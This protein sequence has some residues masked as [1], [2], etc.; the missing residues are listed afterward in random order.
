VT[1]GRLPDRDRADVEALV[2]DH[3]LEALLASSERRAGD[4]PADAAL[5]PALR[6]AARLLQ[7][8]L[9]RVHP[10]FR[11]EERLAAQLAALAAD[12][13]AAQ[14]GRPVDDRGAVV[15]FATPGGTP[16]GR[17]RGD[18]PLD[19][20]PDPLLPAILDGTLDPADD[21]VLEADPRPAGA[22]RPLLLGGAITSAAIS[23]V[24]VAWVAWRAA[25]PIDRSLRA[26]AMTRT[27]QVAHGRRLADAPMTGGG[28]GGTA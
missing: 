24:G 7:R 4:V 13:R 6:D 20:G 2:A 18:A 27:V 8:S 3:Y 10:S 23:L 28:V 21:A 14:V 22:R 1:A 15:A 26:G 5:E 25:R 9:V 19:P 12:R 11:F 17:H 16:G